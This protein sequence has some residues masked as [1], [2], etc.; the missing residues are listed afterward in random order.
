MDPASGVTTCTATL[1]CIR[2][3]ICMVVT[4][5]L[6][7]WKT[8]PMRPNLREFIHL[9][10]FSRLARGLHGTQLTINVEVQL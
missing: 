5:L 3:D 7:A 10:A 9:E 6:R 2:R 1:S 8:S 4:A